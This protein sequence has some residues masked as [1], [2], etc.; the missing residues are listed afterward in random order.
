[1]LLKNT[2]RKPY[3]LS[4]S[5]T[6]NDLEWPLNPISRSRHFLK[7]NIVKRRLLKTKLLLH[8]RKLYLTW[9]YVWWPWLTTKCVALVCQHQLSFLYKCTSLTIAIRSR[10]CRSPSSAINWLHRVF[11]TWLMVLV[12][13]PLPL[14]QSE[15]L[16]NPA[17][18]HDQF[19]RA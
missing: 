2:K 7:S 10:R 19:W 13:T 17:D 16:C 18:G 6:F 11:L 9:Y 14:Q 8:K 1:M 4:N 12:P 5:A 15:Y 3:N